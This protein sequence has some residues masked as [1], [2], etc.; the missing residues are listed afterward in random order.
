MENNGTLISV[1]IP[2]YS[3]E[4]YIGKCVDSI[5]NQDFSDYEI[6]LVDD[7]SPD[8]CGKICDEYAGK[9]DII[10]VVHKENGG[11]SD[12]RNA[13]VNKAAGQ[14]IVFVDSDDYVDNDYLSTLWDLHIKFKTDVAFS[15]AIKEDD[16]IS[17]NVINNNINFK[18]QCISNR[19]AQAMIL[20]G[21][22][23][24][25]TACGKLFRKTICDK[26]P[27]PKGKLMEDL[28]TVYFMLDEVEEIGITTKQTY[29]YIQHSGSIL[30][31]KYDVAEADEYIKLAEHFIE[32]APSREI[33][34]SA[35]TRLIYICGVLVPGMKKESRKEINKRIRKSIRPNLQ[36][37][38]QQRDISFKK[39]IRAVI[40]SLP[41][42]L[43]NMSGVFFR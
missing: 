26:H 34:N 36:Y 43:I 19:D 18:E 21:S 39:K 33:R 9:Y 28:R 10:H 17:K 27:F 41:D 31:S 16:G 13:G 22:V 35:F 29:H 3:V 2:V 32:I 8:N 4:K 11:L 24:G 42:W 38:L 7:G 5:I 40:Y 15:A 20:D 25:T 14:Y 23:I 1:I 30:H 37:I 6:I 12:A